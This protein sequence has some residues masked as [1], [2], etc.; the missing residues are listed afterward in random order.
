MNS[1][2]VKIP[3]DSGE[4]SNNN[5]TGTERLSESATPKQANNQNMQNMTSNN[6]SLKCM[7]VNA[8]SIN[9]KVYKLTELLIRRSIKA[10]GGGMTQ[11]NQVKLI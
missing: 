11:K 1:P 2:F 6:P 5:N 4:S 9:N 8:R 10:I 7:L 3:R